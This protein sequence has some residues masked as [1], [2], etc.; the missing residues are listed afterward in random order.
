M[1]SQRNGRTES[2]HSQTLRFCLH[3]PTPSHC[4]EPHAAPSAWF[5]ELPRP[6]GFSPK[7]FSSKIH[8]VSLV[9]IKNVLL[10]RWA[11]FTNTCFYLACCS[12]I[13][14]SSLEYLGSKVT[15]NRVTQETCVCFPT[16]TDIL[17]A[18][19]SC[20]HSWLPPVYNSIM[21]YLFHFPAALQPLSL[22]DILFLLSLSPL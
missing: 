16:L 12:N 13:H 5:I 11:N 14:T 8:V 18:L 19:G 17:F 22:L 3:S 6:G 7:P 21:H 20:S 15:F 2:V 4:Q 9:H 1:H 10:P